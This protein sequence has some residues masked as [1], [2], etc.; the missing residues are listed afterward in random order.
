LGAS[1]GFGGRGMDWESMVLVKRD[2]CFL[3]HEQS[4]MPSIDGD[5][6]FGRV[7]PL[8]YWE[9]LSEDF[10]YPDDRAFVVS[11]CLLMIL[12]MAW[13]LIDR[14][15]RYL[16]PWLEECVGRVSS[17]EAGE[18]DMARLKET[19]LSALGAARD[20][21]GATPELEADAVWANRT[22]VL[23]YFRSR[24]MALEGQH[25]RVGPGP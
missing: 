4:E 22:F 14:S 24:A 23:G 17:L 3:L 6:D 13:D 25:A 18:A 20:G 12:T 1:L 9:Y 19:V 11:G 16:R 8:P 2:I 21:S 5:W 10:D 7:Y 15:G